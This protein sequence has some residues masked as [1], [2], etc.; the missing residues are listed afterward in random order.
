[1]QLK[2]S[3]QSSLDSH[4][5]ET[6]YFNGD[7]DSLNIEIIITKKGNFKYIFLLYGFIIHV[8]S[9]WHTWAI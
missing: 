7:G 3:Y 6:N 4:F 5:E 1:L 9:C 8:D 2:F